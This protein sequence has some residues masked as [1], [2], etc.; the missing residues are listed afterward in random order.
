[1]TCIL[2][3]QIHAQTFRNLN[4]DISLLYMANNS[5]FLRFGCEVRHGS[6][7]SELIFIEFWGILLFVLIGNTW[8]R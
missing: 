1:M 4:L 5:G 8:M 6:L 3:R 2:E 7:V